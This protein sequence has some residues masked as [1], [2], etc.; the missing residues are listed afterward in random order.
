[1]SN[2]PGLST[3]SPS[4]GIDKLL[5]AT[6]PEDTTDGDGRYYRVLFNCWKKGDSPTESGDTATTPEYLD[7]SPVSAEATFRG[8]DK[9]TTYEFEAVLQEEDRS[10]SESTWVELD[11][12][13]PT[14]IWSEFTTMSG[15][16]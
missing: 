12:Q 8:L 11:R 9:G 15:W 7:S 16:W 6:K 5:N 13:R 1:M 14:G 2:F 4:A 10:G 3:A